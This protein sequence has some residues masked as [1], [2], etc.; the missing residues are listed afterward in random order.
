MRRPQETKKLD[1]EQRC[2][3]AVPQY[4]IGEPLRGRRDGSIRHGEVAIDIGSFDPIISDRVL[5]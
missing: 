5:D 1:A 4:E 2:E 3:E